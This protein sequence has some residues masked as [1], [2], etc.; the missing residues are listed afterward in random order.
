M[1]T[2]SDKNVPQRAAANVIDI[3]SQ[4]Q[5]HNRKNRNNFKQQKEPQ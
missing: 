1:S 2:G 4:R 3:D 5:G